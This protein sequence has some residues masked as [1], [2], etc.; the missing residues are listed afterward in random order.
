MRIALLALLPAL[1]SA[2]PYERML[3]SRDQV[4]AYMDAYDFG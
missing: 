2:G 1:A 4:Q 3:E